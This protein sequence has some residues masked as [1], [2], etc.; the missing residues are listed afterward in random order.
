MVEFLAGEGEEVAYPVEGIGFPSAVPAGFQL[1]PGDSWPTPRH[2]TGPRFVLFG[3]KPGCRLL[4][5]LWRS[6]VIHWMLSLHQ[7]DY[8]ATIP[9]AALASLP[10]NMSIS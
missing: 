7:E 9:V 10:V 4:G 3:A 8:P 5:K 6:S 1:E 2:G